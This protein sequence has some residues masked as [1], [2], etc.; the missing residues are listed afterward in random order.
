MKKLAVLL[1]A[2]LL[3]SPALAGVVFK[4]EVTTHDQSPPRTEHLETA[5]E[6]RL[7]KM[8][9]PAGGDGDP[10]EMVYRGDRRE[11]VWI[12]HDRKAYYVID[13]EKMKELAAQVNEAMAMME[14]ALANVP[15]SQR[16]MVEE[17]M[18]KKMPQTEAPE[19]PKSELRN[20]GDRA[21]QAGYPCVRYEVLRGDRVVRELWV[22]D[23]KNVEG[24]TDAAE[25]FV[26]MSKF[27]TKMLDSLPKFADQGGDET[28]EYMR[29]LNGFPVVTREFDENGSLEI[30]SSLESASRQTLDP[31][32]FEAPPGYNRQ[33]MFKGR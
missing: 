24:G 15:E 25:L 19:R 18:K 6:G 10:A 22:T 27:F 16:A 20:T 8:G 23:W 21:E 29:E 1:V 12:D 14:Q 11:M 32:T 7:L 26:E 2:H 31:S 28:L 3:A 30:E 9:V 17:M 33:E 4:I 13:E 5:V